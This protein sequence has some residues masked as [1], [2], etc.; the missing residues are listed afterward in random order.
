MS[1]VYPDAAAALDG[2]LHDGMLIA[3]GGFGL[4]GVPERL[5][6]TVHGSGVVDLT[7]AGNNAGLDGEGLGKLLNRRQISKMIASYVGDNKEFERQFLAGELEIEFTPARHTR[8]THARWRR[9]DRGLLHPHRR[10]DAD[11]RRAR[12]DDDLRWRGTS[13]SSAA[14]SADLALVKGWKARYRR[15]HRVSQDGAELQP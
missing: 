15:Q 11:R 6:D 7:V 14:S 10:G 1:K 3:V 12:T 2:L 9:R 13:C 5:I 4:C 8:R